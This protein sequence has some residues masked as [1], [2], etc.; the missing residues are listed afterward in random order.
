[1]AERPGRL[2]KDMTAAQRLAAADAFWTDDSEDIQAQHVEALVLLARRLNFRAKSVQALSIERR[3]KF[4][5]QVSEVS[6]AIA[7]RALIAY[8]FKAQRP[9]MAAFLDALGVQHDNG[10]ITEEQLQAPESARLAAA[11]EKTRE[12]FPAE[13]LTL[14]LRT[15]VTLDSDTWGNLEGALTKPV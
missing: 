1:M 13:D 2:W 12:A 6:D 9:L 11:V 4:L 10:L 14:Y 5:A 15:L 3:A 7:T 8:H